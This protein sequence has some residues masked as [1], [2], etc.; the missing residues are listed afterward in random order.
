MP[1]N[2]WLQEDSAQSVY[3]RKSSKPSRCTPAIISITHFG[4]ISKRPNAL[5]I[6]SQ[7]KTNLLWVSTAWSKTSKRKNLCNA[8]RQ[9]DLSNYL[10][11][12]YSCL[13][14]L[15]SWFTFL[16]LSYSE[17]VCELKNFRIFQNVATVSLHVLKIVEAERVALMTIFMRAATLWDA[18][19]H[20]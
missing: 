2:L 13:L 9:L 14:A 7:P 5:K 12:I 20:P 8:F 16:D 11:E 3:N 19:E 4:N 15:S 6:I 1:V 10:C 18:W 17:L